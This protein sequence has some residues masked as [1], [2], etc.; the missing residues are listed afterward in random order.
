MASY[1]TEERVQFLASHDWNSRF[2]PP[3]AGSIE[4]TKE[5]LSDDEIRDL[6]S[7]AFNMGHDFGSG[8][9]FCAKQQTWLEETF[10]TIL[11]GI[12]PPDTRREKPLVN[13]RE[14]DQDAGGACMAG[15]CTAF[16]STL[17]PDGDPGPDDSDPGV[18]QPQVSPPQTGPAPT[19]AE[20]LS[21]VP[22]A[23][24]VPQTSSPSGGSE[25]VT[26]TI[27][28][29]GKK[30]PRAPAKISARQL[31]VGDRIAAYLGRSGTTAQ[32]AADKGVDFGV[33]VSTIYNILKGQRVIDQ[34]LDKVTAALDLLEV[35]PPHQI[36]VTHPG[37]AVQ[38]LP[39]KFAPIT[40]IN[41][42]P[43]LKPPARCFRVP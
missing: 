23:P 19:T 11:D 33:H 43:D 31:D 1:M 8:K 13:H 29:P 28:R 21:L 38:Q 6:V 5:P 30:K 2:S 20:S 39:D 37:I 14:G 42:I 22:P 36:P 17:L 3:I 24:S 7:A 12:G 15:E 26:P 16:V 32:A 4:S 41:P 35:G 34:T 9:S 18:D 25:L 10:Q 40:G 27:A